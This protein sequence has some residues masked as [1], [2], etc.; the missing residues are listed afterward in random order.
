MV[1]KIVIILGSAHGNQPTH[2]MLNGRLYLIRFGD[3]AIHKHDIEL[4]L[5]EI[6]WMVQ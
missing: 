6:D 3:W 1:P 2:M 4:L 5:H